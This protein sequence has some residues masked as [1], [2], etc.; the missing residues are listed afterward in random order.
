MSTQHLIDL[1]GIRKVFYTE[2]M[3]ATALDDIRM[4][5]D[6]EIAPVEAETADRD[7]VR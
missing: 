5:S 6:L 2:E 3:E 7:P 1:Q 4:L